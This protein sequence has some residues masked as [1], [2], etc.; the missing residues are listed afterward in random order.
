[1]H[2]LAQELN[3]T[4]KKDSLP[5]YEMLSDMGRRL[6]FPKGILAQSAE[7]KAKL[8]TDEGGCKVYLFFYSQSLKISPF[9]LKHCSFV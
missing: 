6:Y 3:E 8:I 7:A 1:M 5:V 4:I 2:P 9:L